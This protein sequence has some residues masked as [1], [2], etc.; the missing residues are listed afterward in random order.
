MIDRFYQLTKEDIELANRLGR[1]RNQAKRESIRDKTDTSH[2][3]GVYGE[4]A[5]SKVTGK[6]ID[7]RIFSHGDVT[8]FDGIEVRV[9]TWL[10]S[11]IELKVKF[12]EYE[13][14]FPKAYVLLRLFPEVNKIHFIGSISRK[15]FNDIKYSRFH[16]FADNWCVKGCDLT[17]VIAINN[18]KLELI[19]IKN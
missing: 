1:A 18:D 11:D 8:D 14:K 12:D 6:A 17:N 16:K 10:G 19:E 5:Y 13:R 3:Y 4:I 7:E 15:R 9:S 2:I